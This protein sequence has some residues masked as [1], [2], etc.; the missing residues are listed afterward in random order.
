MSKQRDILPE[1][2]DFVVRHAPDSMVYLCGSLNFGGLR[3]DSDIDLVVIVP[4]LGVSAFPGEIIEWQAPAFRLLRVYHKDMPV[5][6]HLFGS[7][8]FQ[9]LEQKPWR[10]YTLF[11]MEVLRDPK[12]MMQKLKMKISP[13]FDDHPDIVKLW[14]SW[15]DQRKRRNVS[16][17][18]DQGELIKQFPG[19]GMWWQHLDEIMNAK[20]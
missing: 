1:V 16:R 6:I 10:A 14:D 5:H 3:T 2:L 9:E 7:S 4:D 8:I 11:R 12:G 15:M 19:S 20:P 18:K 13:W 17:G